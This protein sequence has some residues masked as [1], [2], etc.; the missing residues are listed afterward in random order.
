MGKKAQK[1]SRPN[2]TQAERIWA[3]Y[4]P[5][6]ASCPYH[7]FAACWA[8]DPGL[9]AAYARKISADPEG[10]VFFEVGNPDRP[11]PAEMGL[12]PFAEIP[13]FAKAYRVDPSWVSQLLED[14]DRRVWKPNDLTSKNVPPPAI[15]VWHTGGADSDF[16]SS[17]RAV[18]F[19][20]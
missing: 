5:H 19:A 7:L 20:T 8:S 2:L 11:A 9:R 4:G 16:I 3:E 17:A 13:M 6:W 18:Y 10:L 15:A 14:W 1:N 12:I